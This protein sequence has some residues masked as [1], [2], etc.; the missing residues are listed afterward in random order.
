[1]S[2]AFGRNFPDDGQGE[3]KNDYQVLEHLAW[4]LAPLCDSWRGIRIFRCRQ[5]PGHS[6]WAH[7]HRT[8]S[9]LHLSATSIVGRGLVVSVQWLV[10]SKTDCTVENVRSRMTQNWPEDV[11]KSCTTI[12]RTKTQRSQKYETDLNRKRIKRERI[13]QV[14]TPG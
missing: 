5:Y 8:E 10:K 9:R 12:T 7:S 1:M 3:M 6:S 4:L 2:S 14:L 13:L 11:R